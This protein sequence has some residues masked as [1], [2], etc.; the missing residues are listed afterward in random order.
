MYAMFGTIVPGQLAL[1]ERRKK[2]SCQNISVQKS[3]TNGPLR[4]LSGV[5]RSEISST[6]IPLRSI[7]YD[8][9]IL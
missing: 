9:D 3:K 6:T 8:R 4:N 5:A 1:Q 2:T 7:D